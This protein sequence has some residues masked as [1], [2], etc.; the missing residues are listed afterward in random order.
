[1]SSQAMQHTVCRSYNQIEKERLKRKGVS[2]EAMKLKK[3]A[4]QTQK[5]LGKTTVKMSH[6]KAAPKHCARECVFC[7]RKEKEWHVF[8]KK[9][10]KRERRVG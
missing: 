6:S 10:E 4:L 3:E 8:L 2:E 5:A 7:R 1:M 9:N